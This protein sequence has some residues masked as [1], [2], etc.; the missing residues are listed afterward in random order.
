MDSILI[1]V[2]KM[3]G[4]TEDYTHFDNDLI[5]HINSVFLVLF[6]L[7]VGPQDHAFQIE[8]DSETWTDFT[9]GDTNLNLI[10]SYIYLKVRMLFDP[11]TSGG[12]IEAVN[13]Q[14]KEFEWRL[15][16]EKSWKKEF[17]N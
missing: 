14:I 5:M 15:C 1:S 12:A 4:I 9:G 16:A 10:R 8:D 6:Q 17:L 11:P 7:G 3:L 13:N 2:K